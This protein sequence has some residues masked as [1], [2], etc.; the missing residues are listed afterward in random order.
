MLF[1]SIGSLSAQSV[2]AHDE[3]NSH[4]LAKKATVSATLKVGTKKVTKA[5]TTTKKT[6]TSNTAS[7]AKKTTTSS[8]AKKNTSSTAK[9]TTTSSTA[10]KTTNSTAKKTTTSSSKKT[11]T[12]NTAKKT[13]NTANTAKKAS[14][15]TTVNKKTLAKTSASFI[16]YVD[17][18]G[19]LPNVKI[20]NKNYSHAEYLY[21]IS[22]A[23]ENNSNS[24]IEIKD[25]LVKAY[26]YSNYKSASGNLNKSE[27]VKIAGTTRKF[28]EK[29]QRA[30]NYV[31]SSKGKIPYKQ[32]ILTFSKCL[33]T[34]N[35]SSKLPNSVKLDDA[36]LDKIKAKIN[37]KNAKSNNGV[38]KTDS[39][40]DS[41]NMKTEKSKL[42]TTK[43]QETINTV[44]SKIESQINNMSLVE[45]SMSYVHNVLNN[46]LYRLDPSKYTLNV[47]KGDEANVRVNTSRFNLDVN[48]KSTVNVEV[49]AKDRENQGKVSGTV[50]NTVVAQQNTATTTPT[51]TNQ[52]NPKQTNNKKA[53]N[54][55]TTNKKTSTK[56]TTAKKTTT[57]ATTTKATT[58]K[59]TANTVNVKSI[60]EALKKYLASTKN[61]QVTN[62]EIQSMA[63]KLTSSLK[64]DSDK[65]KKLF[66]YVRDKIGYEKYANTK[67]GAVKTLQNKIGNCVDKSHLLIALSR[68]AGI[69]AKYVNANN[70]KF[71]SGYVSGHV[72]AKLYLNKKWVVADTTSSRNTLGTIK[73]W[74]TKSYTLIGEYAGINF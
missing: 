18:N 40:S 66:E 56:K 25:N 38:K 42:N 11:T 54:K 73:N 33:D 24:K 46:I 30:P 19:K 70:C 35:K 2:I 31:S 17:K 43:I 72:W 50:G 34:Y 1:F 61:C 60:S 21:L 55:K 10:K 26:N 29:N 52:T 44:G 74:N 15:T 7:T 48:G 49:S 53:T 47:T 59:K 62:K 63:K 14:G 69:P 68:A 51:A 13:T 57:K 22:K 5:K 27:C 23:V 32:L 3:V 37:Q 12:S 6:T 41:G 39:S 71:T 4:K 20:S 67:R 16:S 8:T 36:D 58:T 45:R 9:K 64:S 65:A 28:I